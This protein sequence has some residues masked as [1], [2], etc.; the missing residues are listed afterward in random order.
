MGTFENSAGLNVRNHY[1]PRE[2]V[3]S[4]GGQVSTSHAVKELEIVFDY[5]DLPGPTSGLE[6]E[7]Y[8]PE[9]AVVLSARF[10]T[11]TA[12]AGGTSFDIG[13][14]END[15]TE[16]DNDGL[17]DALLLAETNAVNEWSDASTHTGTNSGALILAGASAAGL[18]A[19][20]YVNVAATGTYT[21]G[22]GKIV[23]EY[24]EGDYDAS[25]RYTAG[26]VKA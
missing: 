24:R 3:D 14:Q 4:F 7:Q 23:I 18:S 17:W 21:A 22:K 8:V 9:G 12:F 26:G 2:V 10:Q 11:I 5:D 25:G 15:G 20:A 1:G 6:M 13:L 19:N 16:I